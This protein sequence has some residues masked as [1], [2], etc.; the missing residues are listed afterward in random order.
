MSVTLL[1]MRSVVKWKRLFI[2]QWAINVCMG[3]PFN[4][5]RHSSTHQLYK[6]PAYFPLFISF[7]H[8]ET[9][10]C[11]GQWSFHGLQFAV[12]IV[13]KRLVSRWKIPIWHFL[14]HD[15]G[16]RLRSLLMLSCVSIFHLIGYFYEKL[17]SNVNYNVKLVFK[18]AVKT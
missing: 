10:P 6:T 4:K 16:Q 18:T 9:N 14:I 2:G 1:R 15:A 13:N 7:M 12:D 17:F 11:R 8:A 5:C 3:G